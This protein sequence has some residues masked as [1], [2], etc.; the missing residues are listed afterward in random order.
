MIGRTI[1]RYRIV[2]RLGE[3]GM[4]SV[5]RADDALLSRP[6]ALKFLPETLAASPEARQRFLREA[7]AASQLDHPGIATVYDTGEADGRVYIA[8][9]LIEG[10]TLAE[11]LKRTG[12][13]PIAEAVR[14]ARAAAEALAHAHGKGVLHRDVTSGNL[15]VTAEGRVVVVDFGLALPEGA[16][17]LTQ[18]QT[19]M[20][21][22]AYLAPEVAEGKPG[23]RRSDLYGLGVVLYEMLTGRLPF[24]GER[25]EAVLAHRRRVECLLAVDADESARET[26]RT[27]LQDALSI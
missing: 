7:R 9:Q 18:S 22:V 17:R 1:G 2:A 5:W 4:G 3:G 6:V 12:W 26:A 11:R 8:L 21:T 19:V 14:I 15:M 20:G 16:T 24:A 13:L 27:L 10:E 25:R 23:D